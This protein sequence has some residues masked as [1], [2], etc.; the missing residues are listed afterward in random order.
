MSYLDPPDYPEPP[1]C[2][3]EYMDADESGLVYTCA[4]CGK[5]INVQPDPPE[6]I[7]PEYEMEPHGCAECGKP[8]DCIYCSE[9]CAAKHPCPH[10]EPAGECDHCAHLADM[11]YDAMRES[12]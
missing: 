10:G 8:T 6:D 1:D 4:T 5:Q 7:F 9:E 3:D 2:C 11:A 12:R